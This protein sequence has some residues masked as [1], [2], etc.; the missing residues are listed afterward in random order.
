MKPDR[1]ALVRN[2][3]LFLSE[4]VSLDHTNFQAANIAR[5]SRW[6]VWRTSL[7]RLHWTVSRIKEG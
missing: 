3:F 7:R 5:S 2:P 6:V 1:S 4:E